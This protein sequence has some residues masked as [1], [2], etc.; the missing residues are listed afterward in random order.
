MSEIT[1]MVDFWAAQDTINHEE[2]VLIVI[3]VYVFRDNEVKLK[4][5]LDSI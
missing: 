1:C 3:A 2:G 5:F 4:S